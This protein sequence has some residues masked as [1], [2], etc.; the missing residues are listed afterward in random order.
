MGLNP[1]WGK[2]ESESPINGVDVGLN[3]LSLLYVLVHQSTMLLP[4]AV[5]ELPYV[6][7]MCCVDSCGHV[8]QTQ[9]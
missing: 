6:S 5:R 4:H 9:I 7:L 1:C 2:C 8:L 3:P